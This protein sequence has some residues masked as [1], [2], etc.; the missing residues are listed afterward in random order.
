VSNPRVIDLPSYVDDR[1]VLTPVWNTPAWQ[2]ATSNVPDELVDVAGMETPDVQRAYFINNSQKDVIR[3]FHFHHHE[4]KY[5]VV[6][7]GM[8]KFVAVQATGDEKIDGEFRHT[9]DENNIRTFV[10]AESKPQ[11]LIIPPGYA[12]GWMSLTDDCLLLAL[13]S[14]TFE[15]SKNDDFRYP[16]D[17]FGDVWGVEPR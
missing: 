5:F 6:L 11:M 1:G 8:A 3:G 4:T 9:F 16:P 10:L 7:R 15:M 12:N 2:A 13:S 17:L 14:S